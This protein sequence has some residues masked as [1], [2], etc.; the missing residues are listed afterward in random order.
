[1]A[2]KLARLTGSVADYIERS[3]LR[4]DPGPL[5]QGAAAR[6]AAGRRPARQPLHRRPTL[7]AAGEQ[8]GVRLRRTPRCRA[9]YTAMFRTT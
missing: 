3:N 8:R 6:Q 4:I 7:D 1:M 2:Q 9:P 5:P